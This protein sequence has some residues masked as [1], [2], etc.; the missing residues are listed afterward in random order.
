MVYIGSSLIRRES[1]RKALTAPLAISLAETAYK[2]GRIESAT[3]YLNIAYAI[4]DSTTRQGQ[5]LSSASP[6]NT[7]GK[8]N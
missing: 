2:A 7:D 3:R 5:T 4:L 6:P 8:A 1:N